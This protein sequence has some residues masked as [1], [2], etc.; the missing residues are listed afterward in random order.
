MAN[1]YRQDLSTA[2]E[3]TLLKW[4]THLGRIGYPLSPLLARQMAEE[5]RHQRYQLTKSISPGLAPRALGK[6]WINSKSFRGFVTTPEIYDIA[7]FPN[8]H[9]MARHHHSTTHTR[10]SL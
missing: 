2:E 5:I 7:L 3:H 1:E 10:L 8:K 6:N 4:I 9:L